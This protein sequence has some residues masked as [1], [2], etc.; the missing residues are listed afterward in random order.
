[1]NLNNFLFKNLLNLQKLLIIQLFKRIGRFFEA[2]YNKYFSTFLFKYKKPFY[3]VTQDYDKFVLDLRGFRCMLG[4]FTQII[5]FL[6]SFNKKYKYFEVWISD[7]TIECNF[8]GKDFNQE[9]NDIYS[10]LMSSTEIKFIIKNKKNKFDSDCSFLS[11]SPDVIKNTQIFSKN[12]NKYFFEKFKVESIPINFFYDIDYSS[13]PQLKSLKHSLDSTFNIVISPTLDLN[14]KVER[15]NR[16][17]GV[18]SEK[19]FSELEALYMELQDRISSEAISDIRFIFL[20]KKMYNMKYFSNV[21]DLRHFEDYGLN[22][23]SIFYFVQSLASWTIGSEGTFQQYMLLSSEM[24]HALYI[25]NHI[26][27]YSHSK[28]GL[29]APFFMRDINYLDYDNAPN[30]YLPKKAQVIEEIFNDY[31]QFKLQK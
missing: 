25:D 8:P 10:L 11:L 27:P 5:Q 14:L 6:V 20:N 12:C 22:F 30:E 23:G 1:M 31:Y 24:K 26:W 13:L 16:R 9:A 7:K 3:R 21:V 28:Y 29:S 17:F 18:I 2:I 15:E 19:T 4:D